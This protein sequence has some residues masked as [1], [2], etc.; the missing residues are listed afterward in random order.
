MQEWPHRACGAALAAA[1]GAPLGELV[2]GPCLGLGLGL[3][4]GKPNPDLDLTLNP[5]LHQVSGLMR[6]NYGQPHGDAG[7][8]CCL[9][10]ALALSPKP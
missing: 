10:L 3:E 1:G 6:N 7:A 2:S 5:N 4:E 8:L 9:T